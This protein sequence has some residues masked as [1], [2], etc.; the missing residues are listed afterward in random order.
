[1]GWEAGKVNKNNIKKLGF[2]LMWIDGDYF[3]H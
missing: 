3:E 2:M 1:M